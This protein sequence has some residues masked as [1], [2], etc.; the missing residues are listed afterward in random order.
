MT[1]GSS[2]D[3]NKSELDMRSYNP[4]GRKGE[5]TDM[6]ATVSIGFEGTLRALTEIVQ[7]LFLAGKGGV[8]YN[9]QILYPDGGKSVHPC[10]IG[11]STDAPQET[12]LPCLL[13]NRIWLRLLLC[14]SR[15]FPC[16]PREIQALEPLN[17]LILC[18][19][20]LVCLSEWYISQCAPFIGDL[21]LKRTLTIKPLKAQPHLTCF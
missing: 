6:G 10:H 21:H 20:S 13:L 14:A 18:E 16:I 15:T 9:E 17:K 11:G 2:N 12:L 8:F 7:I 1:A 19:K 4:A 3:S 5:D